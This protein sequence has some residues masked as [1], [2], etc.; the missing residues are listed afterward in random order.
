MSPAGEA[1]RMGPTP[2]GK[3]KTFW[4]QVFFLSSFYLF[5]FIHS[6]SLPRNELFFWFSNNIRILFIRIHFI[7]SFFSTCRPVFKRKYLSFVFILNFLLHSFPVLY[8]LSFFLL[9]T[10]F[11]PSFPTKPKTIFILNAHITH[12]EREQYGN[13]HDRD[14]DRDRDRERGK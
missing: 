13:R 8:S 1:D 14:R 7:F 11:Y 2:P 9:F 10:Y 5:F 6:P 3:L 4:I 12:T